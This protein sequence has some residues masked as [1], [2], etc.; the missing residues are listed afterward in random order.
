MDTQPNS[1]PQFQTAPQDDGVSPPIIIH[2]KTKKPSK[3]ARSSHILS[4]AESTENLGL[5]TYRDLLCANILSVSPS[6]IL[7]SH[8]LTLKRQFAGLTLHASRTAG[9]KIPTP[10][11]GMT[12]AKDLGPTS[13]PRSKPVKKKASTRARRPTRKPSSNIREVSP[14]GT[15]V[16]CAPTEHVTCECTGYSDPPGA[17]KLTAYTLSRM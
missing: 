11:S 6:S 4:L 16:S 1:Q 9:K 5:L 7:H 17:G 3:P 8:D 2:Y 13:K 15:D 12:D 14:N 10:S